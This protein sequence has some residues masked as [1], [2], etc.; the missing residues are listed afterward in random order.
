M[1]QTTQPKPCVH[2][3]TLCEHVCVHA[4]VFTQVCYSVEGK[5]KKSVCQKARLCVFCECC[6]C[7]HV[8]FCVCVFV[9]VGTR[10]RRRGKVRSKF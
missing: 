10:V 4:C 7:E 6:V 3:Q 1:M 5:G 9:G 2:L 8:F